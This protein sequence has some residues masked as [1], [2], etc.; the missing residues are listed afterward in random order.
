MR[1]LRLLVLGFA[2]TVA[3]LSAGEKRTVVVQFLLDADGRVIDPQVTASDEPLL[4]PYA[5]IMVR[6]ATWD[7]GARPAKG[8]PLKRIET[9][10]AFP[11]ETYEGNKPLPAGATMPEPVKRVPPRYPY[12]CRNMDLSGGAY[13]ALT[14]DKNGDVS[15][16]RA[17]TSAHASFAQE[18]IKA[19]KKW[20]FKPAN[21]DGAAIECTVNIAVPFQLVGRQCGWRWVI[22]PTPALKPYMVESEM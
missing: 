3:G 2:L 16:C 21:L 17:I 9:P 6:L 12:V 14:I 10:L 22:A 1:K 7:V 4:N 18:A 19:F 15:D 5:I 13:L 11:V 8:E 20:K